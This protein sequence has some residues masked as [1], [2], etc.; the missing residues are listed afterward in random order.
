MQLQWIRAH[1]ETLGNER[2]DALAKLAASKDQID[3]ESGPSKAQV[4]NLI[5]D[6]HL[7]AILVDDDEMASEV[8]SD[9]NFESIC[10]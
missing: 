8:D 3:T 2:A 7:N 10:K 1:N 6:I 5:S 9:K 4:R